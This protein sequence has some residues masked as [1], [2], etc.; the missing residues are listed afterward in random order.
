M[1]NNGITKDAFYRARAETYE[2]E[3]P[4][5]LVRYRRAMAWLDVKEGIVVREVGCKFAVLRSL[6]ENSSYY[7]NYAAV[8]I[9]DATLQKIPGYNPE[10][11]KRHDVNSGLPFEDSSVDY[12]F[13]LE[14]LEHLENPTAFMF[15]VKRCLKAGGKLILSVPNPYCW[16]EFLGNY[17]KLPDG[18]GHISSL[19]YQ[20]IDALLRFAGLFL[21][22]LKGTYTRLPLSRRFLGNYKLVETNNIFLT[23]S[24]MFLIEKPR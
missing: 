18:E 14:V 4:E 23:R 21:L 5:A 19:T 24:Y 1:Q 22:D 7:T 12:I 16:M 3:D 17:R 2:V 11:F 6:L 10:Q 20:N 8:D 15:E 9:D 13:C